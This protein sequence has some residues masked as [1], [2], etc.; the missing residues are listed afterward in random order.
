MGLV[1]AVLRMGDVLEETF[2][3]ASAYLMVG[4]PQRVGIHLTVI[5]LDGEVAALV[6]YRQ[7]S[8]IAVDGLVEFAVDNVFIS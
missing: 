2:G 3:K 8:G 1:I 4:E 6:E 7:R 5:A